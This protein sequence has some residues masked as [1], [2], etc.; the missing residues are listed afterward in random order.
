MFRFLVGVIVGIY[1]AQEYKD[2][3]PSIKLVA[4]QLLRQV[5]DKVEKEDKDSKK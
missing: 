1:V 2:Q 4:Q 3:I 5:K